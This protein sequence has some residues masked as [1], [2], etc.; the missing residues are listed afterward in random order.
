MQLLTK[1]KKFTIT[2][3]CAL[4]G[5]CAFAQEDA[6]KIAAE[7]A[8]AIANAELD[9]TIEPAPKY[10]TPTAVFDLGINQ[11]SLSNWAAGGYNTANFYGGLDAHADYA[12]DLATWT[13]R[14]QMQYGFLWSA[15]KQDLFQ[16]STDL[17]YLE[18]KY[19]YKTKPDSKWSY[20]A[21]FDFRS[22]F[23][24][25]YTYNTPSEGQSWRDAA[26]LKS[27]FLSP[28]YTNIALGMEW[29]PTPW[30]NINIAPLTGGFTICKIESLR[31]TYGMELKRDYADYATEDLLPSYYKSA[32]FQFGA[33]IKANLKFTINEVFAY[34]TQLVLFSDYLDHPQNLR[35]NWDNKIAWQIAKYFKLG[36]STWLIYDPIVLIDGVQRVQFKEFTS[37]TFTYTLQ[38]KA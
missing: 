25:G 26:T 12:K 13:N 18:S 30:F 5:I 31:P 32:K 19:G 3:I 28:A 21:S 6:Q 7:A 16:K 24:N 15:D 11:T 14:L 34:E 36:F 17:L 20:T 38:R 10:W 4:M 33:Q 37:F 29:A 23:T 35:V 27:G 2:L 9:K 22:Q 1:M 8:A